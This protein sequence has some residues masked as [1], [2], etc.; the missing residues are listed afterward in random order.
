MIWTLPSKD[1][2]SEQ[3]TAGKWHCDKDHQHGMANVIITDHLL[4]RRPPH[5]LIRRQK[6]VVQIRLGRPE[7]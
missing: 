7:I 3:L 6:V 5:R 1:M 2:A 4:L